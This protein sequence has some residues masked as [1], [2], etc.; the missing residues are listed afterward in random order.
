MTN[1]MA[2]VKIT[3]FTKSRGAAKASVRYITHRPGVDGRVTSRALYT[4]DGQV[5][6]LDA[7]QMI[8]E[9]KRGANF[10]RI[11]ISPDPEKEDAFKDLYL[12]QITEQTMLTLEERLKIQIPFIAAE[13][14]DHTGNRHIHLLACA[15]ARIEKQDLK[16]LRDAATDVALGQ[17]QERDLARAAK[18][19]AVEEAQWAY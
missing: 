10:F 2:I 6:K 5:S 4:F 17:R 15:K 9:A 3:S 19:R 14:D 1:N 8:D 7:Y 11:V 12:W 16:A 13:H 18:L